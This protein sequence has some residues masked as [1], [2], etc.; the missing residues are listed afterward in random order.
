MIHRFSKDFSPIRIILAFILIFLLFDFIIGTFLANGIKKY[1]GLGSKAELALVGHSH[2]MLGV[3]KDLLEDELGLSVSKYTRE[4]VNVAERKLMVQQLL[5]ESPE[6]N[7][8]V[9][10]VDAWMFTGK[11]LS[12]N[13][14]TLFYPF[15]GDKAI[16]AYIKARTG[17]L[18]YWKHK[19][20]KTTRYDEGLI[21]S[22]IRGYL[23]NWS[24][25]KEGVVDTVRLKR[26]IKS[27][28][29][30]HIDNSQSNIKAL[31]E[32]IVELGKKNITVILLYVP[33]INFINKAEP[34]LFQESIAIFEELDGRYEHV[35]FLDYNDFYAHDHCLFF[36]PIH[37]NPKGQQKV[38]KRLIRDLKLE[39]P[40]LFTEKDV[41]FELFP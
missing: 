15:L 41:R 30:R 37:M 19:V 32:T 12:A 18:E 27:K 34:E 20:L 8:I 4:G 9:Y 24:N 16:D 25:F 38:T 31:R 36:D 11:G 26:E 23:G 28:K 3:D 17:F 10:G 13:S 7:T 2:L 22:A 39:E 21:N 33:T 1:Y 5:K 29:F 6:I 35:T 14:H 40:V